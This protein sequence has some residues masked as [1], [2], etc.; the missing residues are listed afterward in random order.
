MEM[1]K[2]IKLFLLEKRKLKQGWGG[3]VIACNNKD[4]V[5]KMELTSMQFLRGRIKI[6]GQWLPEDRLQA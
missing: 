6:D 2:E 4:S 5:W 1:M 3:G